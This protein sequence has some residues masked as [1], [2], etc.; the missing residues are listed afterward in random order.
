MN[1]P[2]I[3]LALIELLMKHRPELGGESL[4]NELAILLECLSQPADALSHCSDCK[5]SASI[6]DH[7]CP[8]AYPHPR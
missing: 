3:R 1:E 6:G 7:A 5:E 2:E 8:S 4:K